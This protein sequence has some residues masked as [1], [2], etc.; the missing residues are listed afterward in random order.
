MA[1]ERFLVTGGTGCIGAWVVRTLVRESVPV[2]LLASRRRFDRLG[3]LLSDAEIARIDVVDGDINDLE[4]I[5]DAARRQGVTRLIHLAGLQFPFCAADPVAGARVN[6]QGT[7]TMLELVYA[8]SAAVYGPKTRYADDVLPPDAE[9][10]PTSHYGVFKVANEQGARVAW[11][12]QGVRSVGLR[13]HSV[14][15]PGRDQGVTSKP[16][17]A[18]IAAAAGRTYHVNFGGRYQFQFGDDAAR[19]FI[20]AARADLPEATVF[21]LPGPAIG[22]D[23]ILAAIETLEPWAAGKMTFEDRSLP[24]PGAFDGRPL[25]AA[26]GPQQQTPLADG[27]RETIETY[28]RA[29]RDGRLGD[30]YLDRVLAG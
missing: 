9:L 23:E 29:I 22:V 18:M 8:S 21:S 1:D 15:G 27:V 4:T 3:L 13:P 14:Y 7:V 28:R 20:A 5:E 6:V 17:V 11:E 12:T 26:I 19:S 24:F 30:A 2:T 16:T 25:E 10:H